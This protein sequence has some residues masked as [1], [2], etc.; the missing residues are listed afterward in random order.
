MPADPYQLLGVPPTASLEE[1]K[2]AYRRK[3]Q[4]FHPDRNPHPGAHERFIELTEAYR[5]VSAAEPAAPS[6]PDPAAEAAPGEDLLLKLV[7]SLKQAALGDRVMVEYARRAVCPACGGSGRWAKGACLLC[8]GTS[9]VRDRVVLE[10]RI[11]PGIEDGSRIRI[12]GAGDAGT[13]GGRAGALIVEVRIPPHPLLHREGQRLRLDLPLPF[14]L[15][16]LGGRVRVPTPTGSAELAIPAGTQD[17]DVL[18]LPGQGLPRLNGRRRS[19]L[20]IRIRVETPLKL[21][22]EARALLSEFAATAGERAYPR[23]ARYREL[24]S[25][26]LA[27]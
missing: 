21:N 13:F 24:L 10:V 5:A 27:D 17:G 23:H 4:R 16:A 8:R 3:A 15:A 14:P 1:I 18:R 12:D 7:G 26:V 25:R 22:A 6:P 11:P 2:R 9:V 19:D 20:E